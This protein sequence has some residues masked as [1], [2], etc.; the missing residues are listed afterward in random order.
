MAF[1][2]ILSLSRGSDLKVI[3]W[4]NKAPETVSSSLAPGD[5]SCRKIFV[6]LGPEGGFTAVEVARAEAAGF[7]R[8]AMGPRVLRAESAS[9]AAL[10]AVQTLWGDLAGQGA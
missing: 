10:A 7:N 8:I 3:F 6:L 4:E 9:V 1:K 2:E 5:K